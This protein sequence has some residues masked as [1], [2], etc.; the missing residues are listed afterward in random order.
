MLSINR[1]YLPRTILQACATVQWT[2]LDAIIIVRVDTLHLHCALLPDRILNRASSTESRIIPSIVLFHAII[3]TAQ[4]TKEELSF[5]PWR[6]IDQGRCVGVETN[7]W[8][9]TNQVA[10]FLFVSWSLPFLLRDPCVIDPRENGTRN[11]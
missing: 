4:S 10:Q 11:K 7:V 5:A 8:I 2:F 3:P 1:D 6:R 9:Q